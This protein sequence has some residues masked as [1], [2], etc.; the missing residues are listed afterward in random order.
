MKSQAPS[1]SALDRVLTELE[2]KSKFGSDRRAS[3]QIEDV[4]LQ[5]KWEPA[6]GALGVNL[7][8]QDAV[9]AESELAVVRTYSSLALAY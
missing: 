2:E 6:K 1:R 8:P 7:T 5:V 4:S 9:L 3:D